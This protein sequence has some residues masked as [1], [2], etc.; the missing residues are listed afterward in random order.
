MS[1]IDKQIIE[2]YNDQ[3]KST[4]E[5]AKSLD[6]YPNKVRRTLIKHGYKLKNKS[7]AQKNAL[8]TGRCSHPTEGKTRTEEEKLNISEGMSN[9]WENM[10]ESERQGRVDQAK[11]TS[12]RCHQKSWKGRL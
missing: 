9:H 8:Q 4:Y 10:S 3:S 11:E 1:S 7:E 6:T 12:N 5:I 2:M